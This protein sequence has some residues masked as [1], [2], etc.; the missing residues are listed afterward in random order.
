MTEIDPDKLLERLPRGLRNAS[1]LLAGIYVLGFVY[2]KTYLADFGF[3]VELTSLSVLDLLLSHRYF[4]GQHFF[5]GAGVMQAYLYKRHGWEDLKK[6]PIG[7]LLALF[8]PILLLP[9]AH[10]AALWSEQGVPVGVHIDAKGT[11][12]AFLVG[13][14]SGWLIFWFTDGARRHKQSFQ[15]VTWVIA[16]ILSGI[17]MIYSYRLYESAVAIDRQARGDFQVIEQLE[18]EGATIPGPCKVIHIDSHALYLH[19]GHRSLERRVVLRDTL[20]SYRVQ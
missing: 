15:V 1:F 16:V 4:A 9:A 5:V 19:C 10:F 11:I 2:L 14:I 3:L 8:A 18:T 6:T 17:A 13:W 7:S 12:L 20:R